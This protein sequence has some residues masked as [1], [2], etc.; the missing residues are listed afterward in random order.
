MKRQ[1]GGWPRWA[2]KAP[3]LSELGLRLRLLQLGG[4]VQNQPLHRSAVSRICDSEEP[5]LLSL[6]RLSSDVLF[7]L[8]SRKHIVQEG[9][10]DANPG[11]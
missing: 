7:F 3:P 8:P 6:P 10:V 9:G 5:I 4:E 11:P 2:S 1:A